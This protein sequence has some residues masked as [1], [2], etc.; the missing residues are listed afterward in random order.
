MVLALIS[1]SKTV[2]KKKIR[3][4]LLHVSENHWFNSSMCGTHSCAIP[5]LSYRH[6][7]Q[8]QQEQSSDA[9]LFLILGK[10][11][12]HSCFLL[13]T[14]DITFFKKSTAITE[15]LHECQKIKS[16]YPSFSSKQNTQTSI[17]GPS[18]AP[19]KFCLYK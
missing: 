6:R 18:R 5:C 2:K 17:Q 8:L 10:E 4:I 16:E 13:I 14:L 12:S 3:L 11:H 9:L 1:L 7:I 15:Q 19:L